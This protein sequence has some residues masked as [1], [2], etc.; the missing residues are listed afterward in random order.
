MA[1]VTCYWLVNDAYKKCRVYHDQHE[2][3]VMLKPKGGHD[4]H[5]GIF[6]NINLP[7]AMH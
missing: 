2:Q 6:H 1:L 4:E 3:L 5:A 7:I